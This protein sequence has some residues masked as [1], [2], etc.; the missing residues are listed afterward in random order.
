MTLALLITQLFV[1]G[2]LTWGICGYIRLGLQVRNMIRRFVNMELDDI[3]DDLLDADDVT[4]WPN[5]QSA[6][7]EDTGTTDT[8]YQQHRERLAVLAAGGRA[9][10]YLGK[11]L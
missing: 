6:G 9:R 3:I 11:A 1:L 7:G 4:L 10:Q 8:K 2:I 5:R